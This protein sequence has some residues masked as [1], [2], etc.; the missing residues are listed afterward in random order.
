VTLYWLNSK[1]GTEMLFDSFSIDH[2]TLRNRVVMSPMC[3]YSAEQDGLA[4]DWHLVHYATRA[5]GQ[6]GLIIIEATGI[7]DRGRITAND[8]GLWN[9]VQ[10]ESLKKLVNAIHSQGAAAAIQL[11]HAGRKSEVP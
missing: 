5:T 9:D 8:L 7:E 10:G 4:T 6:V 11:N 3:M 1:G 2:L